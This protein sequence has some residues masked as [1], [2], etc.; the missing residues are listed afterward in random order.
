MKAAPNWRHRLFQWT[1]CIACAASAAVSTGAE[2]SSD[3]ALKAAYLH[4][5]PGYIEWPK[6]SNAPMFTIA[7]FGDATVAAE[8]EKMLVGRSIKDKPARVLKVGSV[9]EIGDAQM[10]FIGSSFSSS[11]LRKIIA[12]LKGEPV[13][14]VTDDLHG[15]ETGSAINFTQVNRRVRFE[16]SLTAAKQARLSISSELLNVAAMVV[17]AAR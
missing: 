6:N 14:V 4:R 5:F 12:E 15:L 9:S 2:Q 7:V 16:V 3:A 13:L 10:L 1:L 11:G 8:L 17:G